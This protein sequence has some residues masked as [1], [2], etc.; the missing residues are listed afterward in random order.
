MG[1]RKRISLYIASQLVDL[2]DQSFIL[3][4]YTMED[5][6]NPTI[7]HNSFSKQIV[8]TG[9]PTNNKIF[10]DMFRMDRVTSF[11]TRQLGAYFDPSRKTSFTIYNEMNEI[12]EA[13]YCKLDK[14]VKNKTQIDYHITLYGGLGSFFYSLSYDEQGEKRTL[15]DLRYTGS[16]ADANELNFTINKDSVLAAWKRLEGDTSQS[17]LWDILNFAPAYNGY[18]TGSFD[19]NKAMV[20]AANAGIPVPPNYPTSG[21]FVLATLPNEHTEWETKD[22]RS[23]LQR[24]VIK[25]SKIIEAIAQSYNNGGYN[26][27]L[28]SAFFSASNPYYNNSYLTLPIINT[29][30]VQVTQ[31]EGMLTLGDTVYVPD[32]GNPSTSYRIQLGFEPNLN[33]SGSASGNLFMHSMEDLSDTEGTKFLYRA[34]YLTFEAVAYDGENNEVARK[35]VRVSTITSSS[36]Y[37]VPTIDVIGYF[38]AS[39]KWNGDK[40]EISLESVGISYIVITRRVDSVWTTNSGWVPD[41]TPSAMPYYAWQNADGSSPVEIASYGMLTNSS[42]NKYYYETT[43]TARSGAIITKRDLLSSDKTPADYLLSFCKMFGL[44]FKFD[45]GTKTVTISQR[46]NFYQND[47]IDIT[48]RVNREETITPFCFDSKWY[49]FG[50]KIDKGEYANYYA[51]IYDRAFGLQRVNTGY[52]FNADSKDLMSAV[53]FKGAAEVLENS[54]YFMDITQGNINIPS[55]FL[56]AGSVYS[57]GEAEFD[58]PTPSF[59]ASKRWL[60][61][62]NNTFDI[63]PKLQFHEED[64]KAFEERDT[65]VFFRG[66]KSLSG[67]TN[68]YAVTDDN[69]RMMSLNGNTPCWLLDY[70][71]VNPDCAVSALPMFSR[72]MWSE[73]TIIKSL[74]FGTPAEVSIPDVQF[75]SQSSI[76]SQ[77]WDNYIKDRWDNDSR[78]LTCKVDLSG[79]QVNESLF[80]SFYYYDN[81]IW[82]LNKI[83]NHS[84][85]T[86]DDTECELIKVQDINNYTG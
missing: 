53:I 6:A 45:K 83:I 31:G 41:V 19:A 37:P 33:L 34:N 39:G 9:S 24:P 28:D 59:A 16:T 72:Y 63:F 36:E 70:Q 8:L 73:N 54:K 57:I 47:I 61:T 66:M 14:V 35:Q 80:Q 86:W 26:V 42:W 40:V 22:L 32:G 18:P 50:L 10:G 65:L 5:M 71:L 15:A 1:K 17:A 52:D 74:D 68:R 56:D 49:N 43:S 44:V 64:N 69:V 77:Y 21:G 20:H 62:E 76:Y 7:V 85:T 11:G 12:I 75:D 67:I 2:D 4:N 78:V 81:A 79:F 13:G 55:V 60:N 58:I 29:L 48:K 23:Y 30:D 82:A 51:N 3:L 27:A 25:M 84:L 46:K 38:D